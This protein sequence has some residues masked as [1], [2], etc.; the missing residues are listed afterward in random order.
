M[1]LEMDGGSRVWSL[2]PPLLSSSEQILEQNTYCSSGKA[3]GLLLCGVFFN[4][5]EY[6]QTVPLTALHLSDT[7]QMQ[8]GGSQASHHD[9]GSPIP[10]NRQVKFKWD[11]VISHS[12]L[13][14]FLR[15][16]RKERWCACVSSGHVIQDCNTFW[17]VWDSRQTV[18]FKL[19]RWN[20]ETF[21][22]TKKKM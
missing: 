22:L 3:D 11:I 16:S 6:G 13:W 9:L 21:G 10:F 8:R 7:R 2:P 4:S 1:L 20:H 17:V 19:S 18:H 12:R 14:H 5:L 15:T